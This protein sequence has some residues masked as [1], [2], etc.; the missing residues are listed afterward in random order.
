MRIEYAF[1]L[2]YGAMA[3]AIVRTTVGPQLQPLQHRGGLKH[4]AD[5]GSRR[6]D[7]TQ[8]LAL[9]HRMLSIWFGPLLSKGFEMVQIEIL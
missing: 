8:Y 4:E 3:V 6:L 9:T 1:C 2:I 5:I 7:L